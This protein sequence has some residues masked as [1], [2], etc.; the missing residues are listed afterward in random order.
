M[1]KKNKK[2]ILMHGYFASIKILDFHVLIGKICKKEKERRKH[3]F[4]YD[5]ILFNQIVPKWNKHIS[6]GHPKYIDA[7]FIPLHYIIKQLSIYYCIS[8][9]PHELIFYLP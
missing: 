9:K 1:K 4:I 6:C 3:L 5:K 8:P 2:I 7:I